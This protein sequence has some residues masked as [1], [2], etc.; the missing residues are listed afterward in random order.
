LLCSQHSDQVPQFVVNIARSQYGVGD[1][2]A[3]NLAVSL[4]QSVRRL[5]HRALCH[6]EF[7]RC[8]RRR[9]PIGFIRERL[10]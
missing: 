8:V 10:L 7:V 9:N 1:F 2:L 5:S 4:P 3:Q 6:A